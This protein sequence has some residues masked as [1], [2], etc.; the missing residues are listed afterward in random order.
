MSRAKTSTS[1]KLSYNEQQEARDLPVRIDAL[2]REQASLNA[3]MADPGFY[4]SGGDVITETLARLEAIEQE[5]L[6][7]Y[8][9]WTELDA[10][11]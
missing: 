3:S 6:V 11:S 9:R 5:L 8:A 1:K 2:E 10:R 4:R 7:A